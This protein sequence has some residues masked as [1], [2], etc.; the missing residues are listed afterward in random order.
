V[1]GVLEA[2]VAMQSDRKDDTCHGNRTFTI[3]C[4]YQ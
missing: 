2:V 1:E 4:L 3:R